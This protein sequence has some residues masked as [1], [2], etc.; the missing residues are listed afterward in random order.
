MLKNHTL[1]YFVCF[2]KSE[3]VR[4]YEFI[5]EAQ[6]HRKVEISGWRAWLPSCVTRLRLGFS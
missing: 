3:A 6:C 2:I 1:F 5:G 4:I